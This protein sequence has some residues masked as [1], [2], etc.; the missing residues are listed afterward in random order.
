M[1]LSVTRLI[2]SLTV[3]MLLAVNFLPSL[4]MISY[5]LEGTSE[6]VTV[7]GNF[8][9]GDGELADSASL[10]VGEQDGKIVLDVKV[11]GKGYLKSGTFNF[12]G[13]E[14]FQV[15][16]NSDV[17]VNEGKVKVKVVDSDN[18]DQIVL[19]IEF[20]TK[21]EY[22]QNYFNKKNKIT[23]SGLYVDNT[24][25]EQKIEKDIVLTLAWTESFEVNVE[26]EV[27]KNV[28][29]EQ[30]G[31]NKKIVQSILKIS[32]S[33]VDN[34][35][36]V[37]SSHLEIDIPQIPGMNLIDKKID[38]NKLSFSQGTED[39]N[40]QFDEG[41]YRIDD[42]VIVVDVSSIEGETV[43]QDN[44]AED[45]YTL[46]F[47]YEG[48]SNTEYVEGKVK[49]IV[50]GFT[51]VT[52][53]N[54]AVVKYDLANA[55]KEAVSYYR[56]NKTDTISLGYL[57]ANNIQ[58]RYDISYN[59]KDIL[60]ISRSELISSIEVQD[61]DEYFTT[62]D[63]RNFNMETNY[64]ST[65]F[66]K[67]EIEKVLGEDGYIEILNQAGDI[68]SKVETRQTADEEGNIVVNYSEDIS[69]ISFRTS[70]PKQDGTIS[71]LSN[72]EFNKLD[73]TKEE[74]A[75]F[76]ELINASTARAYFKEGY[77]D[78]LG[79]VQS[80]IV[81]TPTFTNATISCSTNILSTVAKNKGVNFQIYLNNSE[82]TSDLYES[83]VFEIKFPSAVIGVEVSNINLFYANN[84]L[85]I[86]GVE[87]VFDQEGRRVLRIKLD[88]NQISYELN[89]ETNGTVISVDTDLTV[90]EFTTGITEEIEM[91]YANF[92]ATGYYNSTEWRML[93][94][95]SGT[96]GVCLL[97]I[98]YDAPE[99]LV[100]AQTTE[101]EVQQEEEVTAEEEIVS[102]EEETGDN[103]KVISIKQGVQD[104]FLEEGA[105]AQLATMTISVLNNTKKRYTE[106]NILG[107]IPFKGNRDV[108]TGEDLG[109]TVDTILSGAIK[110]VDDSLIY[111]VYYSENELAT[112]DLF[113][114]ENGWVTDF[115]KMGAIKSYLIV[116]DPQ[117]ILEP[118]DTLEFEY[119]YIIPANLG[120]GEAMYGTYA[121]FYKEIVGDTV[122]DTVQANDSADAVGYRTERKATIE[123]SFNLLSNSVQELFDADF[124]LALRNTSD[125]D[126]EN[127]YAQIVMPEYLSL[128]EVEGANATYAVEGQT[129]QLIIPEIKAGEEQV[130][131]IKFN[132]GS[133][134]ETITTSLTAGIFGANI[135]DV[136][137]VTTPEFEISQTD[138]LVSDIFS[139]YIAKPGAKLTNMYSIINLNEE[140][141]GKVVI[142]K[143]VTEV[144]DIEA[145]NVQ[146]GA[147]DAGVRTEIDNEK[148]LFRVIIDD[149]ET[150]KIVS[151]TY[152]LKV[153][154]VRKDEA[155]SQ[156][157][158][159]TDIDL[160]NEET[161]SSET[162]KPYFSPVLDVKTVSNNESGFAEAG[163][164]VDYVYEIVNHCEYDIYNLGILLEHTDNEK[165]N[166]AKVTTPESERYYGANVLDTMYAVLKPGQ[167]ATVTINAE[168][169]NNDSM[170]NNNLKLSI[171]G[172]ELGK[173][174]YETLVEENVEGQGHSIVGMAFLDR[175]NNGKQ[176][177][178]EEVL[179]GIIVNLYDS[180]TNEFIESE[181]T[182]VG[183]RYEFD[184][185]DS[186]QY[187]VKFDYDE[188]K[189]RVNTGDKAK[190]LNIKNKNLTDN[191]KVEN[192][193]ISNVDLSLTDENVFDLS[194]DATVDKITVQNNAESTNIKVE[195]NKLAKVDINPEV[196]KDSKVIIEYKVTVKNQG[197][198]PGKVSK[199]VD[200]LPKDFEFDSSLSPDWYLDS[201]GNLYTRSLVNEYINPG[202]ERTLSL[203]LTRNMTGENTGLAHN[204]FEIVEAMNDKGIKD[205]DSS[206]GN[207]VSEDDFS[208]ADVIIGIQTG[209]IIRQ[210]PLIVGGLVVAAM[211]GVLV[212]RIIDRRRYV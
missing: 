169:L 12:D 53:E 50:S 101:I 24:G 61:S 188:T 190:V 153:N 35:L 27:V 102:E 93:T 106:F 180:K 25:E 185:R 194:L 62:E 123:L 68:I 154:Y 94:E 46:T 136:I 90:D 124:E 56:E 87:T 157:K 201:D 98:S 149:F 84:E 33:N 47:M 39:S 175:N 116:L 29:Y 5:A 92:S 179:D 105:E 9:V 133:I 2:A 204:S 138:F 100:N 198:V 89:K 137:T 78:D 127:V 49:A 129:L 96:N 150:E 91:L 209:E 186:G 177:E 158:I 103:S 134:S 59:K 189:Y 26:N 77:S 208:A 64:K 48:T 173:A 43:K 63:G 122:L 38:A 184:N 52:E 88:G 55:T 7:S 14:N 176:D 86:A 81:V 162:Y 13:T 113:D 30:D 187:Y 145:V 135:Q 42:K 71:V 104:G 57:I 166:Y 109:T 69:K 178:D 32:N 44:F 11:N 181:I 18:P 73:F 141:Y 23:F 66:S 85:S 34:K 108:R 130:A 165:I 31:V 191:I 148:H 10:D 72:K 99:G 36:P 16:E 117:Y 120:Q 80:G 140:S 40:V 197:S 58:S 174:E 143:N 20:K 212:W 118:N 142:T 51:G 155:I 206:P 207:K 8:Q 147:E 182:N 74:V 195:N 168:V 125:V 170:V 196:V 183:G 211:I 15:K 70:E 159:R 54:V 114:E 164:T 128:V 205:I 119:D 167:N 22:D 82:D 97:P 111:D 1:K 171:D 193:S 172:I 203:I 192:K 107:R 163:E 45:I 131:H 132:V 83:P 110:S 75:T 95:G 115:N 121:S 156:V 199:I 151:F 112:E 146:I 28:E 139:E 37:Q 76:S 17:E 21:A 200:Y 4:K 202:E 152:D 144:F 6:E 3:L 160:E 79:K 161:V 126:A 65:S 60:N 210:L 67:A 41:N 19:P